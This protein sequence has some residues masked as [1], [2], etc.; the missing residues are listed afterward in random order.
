ML[1]GPPA[2]GKGT[3]ASL[4]SGKYQIP[5]GSTGAMLREEK[6]NQTE[7]GKAAEVFTREGRYFP[8]EIALAV[9]EHWLALYANEGKFVLDGFPRTL[10]Q[11]QQFDEKLAERG[12]E[13]DLAI[14]LEIDEAEIRARIESRLTCSQCGHTFS[15]RVHAVEEGEACPDCG[16]PLTRRKDDTLATLPERL[17]QH[18]SLTEP[19]IAYYQQTGRLRTVSAAASSEAIFVEIS[20]LLENATA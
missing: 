8:D 16:A 13:L 17:K 18:R 9:V 7:L 6:R 2:S 19:V 1:L 4:I 20:E 11:A 12:E 3:I 10:G 14:N 5:T 15:D